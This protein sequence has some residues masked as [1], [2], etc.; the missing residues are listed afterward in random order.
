MIDTAHKIVE[1]SEF[2]TPTNVSPVKADVQVEV[3][4]TVQVNAQQNNEESK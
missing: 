1:V 3:P 2:K 4:D